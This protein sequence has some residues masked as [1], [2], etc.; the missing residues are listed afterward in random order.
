[1]ITVNVINQIPD[2]YISKRLNA[3]NGYCYQMI[4]IKMKEFMFNCLYIK[5]KLQ[6]A[7]KGKDQF[8]IMSRDSFLIRPGLNF[9]QNTATA[10]KS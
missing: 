10:P 1:M 3:D 4:I 6:A 9:I 7:L 5:H 8:P 2:L